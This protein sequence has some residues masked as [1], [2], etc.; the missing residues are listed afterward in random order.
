[1]FWRRQADVPADVANAAHAGKEISEAYSFP[2]IAQSY[3][4]NPETAGLMKLSGWHLKAP[5][6]HA[7]ADVLP[8][9]RK[10][11]PWGEGRASTIPAKSP[12]VTRQATSMM[13]SVS[14]SSPAA[15]AQSHRHAQPH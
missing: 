10:S 7:A 6:H 3:P 2:S 5:N 4:H 13:V 14:G 1:M 8:H 11:R 15:D 12:S 9:I